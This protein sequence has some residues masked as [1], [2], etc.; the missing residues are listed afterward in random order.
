MGN[1]KS[2]QTLT[3]STE[4]SP[5]KAPNALATPVTVVSSPYPSPRPRNDVATF[6]IMRNGYHVIRGCM[7]LITQYLNENNLDRA[8][9]AYNSLV[10]WSLIYKR[11]EEGKSDGKSPKGMFSILDEYFDGIIEKNHLRQDSRDLVNAQKHLEDTTQTGD[12]EKIKEA[13]AQFKVIYDKYLLEKEAIT[14]S[15]V[16]EMKMSHINMK[17]LMVEEILSNVVHDEDDFKFFV[18]HANYILDNQ[19]HYGESRVLSFN[20]AL[21]GCA[22]PV[23]WKRWIKFIKQSLSEETFEKF[24][25]SIRL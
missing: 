20:H 8:A 17:E 16:V 15:R 3:V 6:A 2:S 14:M 10:R 25:D 22:T 18:Q 5:T 19:F 9:S 13:F 24:M 1:C 4:I 11:L 21:W 12:I 23:Q 7:D